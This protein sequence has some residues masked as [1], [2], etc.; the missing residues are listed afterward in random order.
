MCSSF[1]SFCVLRLLGLQFTCYKSLEAWRG[2][3]NVH[4][5]YGI[6]TRIVCSGHVPVN[7]SFALAS[8]G[9]FPTCRMSGPFIGDGD[10]CTDRTPPSPGDWN[11]GAVGFGLWKVPCVKLGAGEG[12][13]CSFLAFKA[14]K[15]ALAA[16]AD[17]VV[18]TIVVYISAHALEIEQWH[19]KVSLGT[20]TIPSKV[21]TSWACRCSWRNEDPRSKVLHDHDREGNFWSDWWAIFWPNPGLPYNLTLTEPYEHGNGFEIWVQSRNLKGQN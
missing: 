4:K 10:A 5:M 2:W 13:C 15:R 14:S 8:S 17:R 20:P 12:G 6:K 16:W 9:V 11:F 1:E 7:L 18:L 3:A 21:I 19:P